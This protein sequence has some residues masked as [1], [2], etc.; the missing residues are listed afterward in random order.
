MPGYV[1][2]D[3]VCRNL[4]AY[5]DRMCAQR[6]IEYANGVTSA[7]ARI[8]NN[9]IDKAQPVPV[10]VRKGR[11]TDYSCTNCGRGLD[12]NDKYCPGCGTKIDWSKREVIEIK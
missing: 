6:K 2:V 5:A 3:G 9:E 7:K 4:L 1:S 8:E 12:V 11:R 10:K